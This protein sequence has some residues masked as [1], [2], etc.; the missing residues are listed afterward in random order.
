MSTFLAITA[1]IL[2]GISFLLFFAGLISLGLACSVIIINSEND[3]K[4]DYFGLMV[5]SATTLL[6][7]IGSMAASCLVS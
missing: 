3:L 5:I 6:F 7:F 2:G 4:K 1:A